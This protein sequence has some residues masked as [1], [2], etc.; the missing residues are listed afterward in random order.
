MPGSVLREAAND[1]YLLPSLGSFE[2][3]NLGPQA[4][5]PQALNG[6]SH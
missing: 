3:G 2:L 6:S 1:V 5:W 4:L